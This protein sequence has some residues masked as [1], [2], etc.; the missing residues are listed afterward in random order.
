MNLIVLG[1]GTAVPHAKRASA[2]HWLETV[3]GNVLLDMSADAPH[4]M[5]E[6]QLD[7][8]NVDAIWISHFHLDHLGGVAPFLFATRSAPQTQARKKP[9][10][11]FGAN[12]LKNIVDVINGAN[13][14]RLFEQLF[15]VEVIEVT[16]EMEFELL[17]GLEAKTRSTP[18][19][20]E[21]MAIRLSDKSGSVL[22]Y[23]SDTGYSDELGEFAKGAGVLLM[24]C[25][26][27]QNTPVKKHLE[28]ADA[29]KLAKIA[30][31]RKLVLSHLYSE[32]DGIDLAAEAKQFW[33]G[34]TIEAYDGLRLQF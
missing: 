24:E 1:S 13:N 27:F 9:L 3:G 11:I 4:R 8:P 32:W 31:P 12:G 16:P 14:Y 6:E 5:A 21:S 25:S 22:V 18:H 15:P 17:P 23:T 19:T 10:R 33:T 30:E 7:W 29:M 2:A 28:L 26:F 34:E 20:N